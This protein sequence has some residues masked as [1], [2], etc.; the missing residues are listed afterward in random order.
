MHDPSSISRL[1]ALTSNIGCVATGLIPDARAHVSRARQEAAE[2]KYKFGYDIP[3]DLLARRIANIN[4]VST[5]E[6]AMRPLGTAL[7]LIAIDD[8]RG[9]QV[10]KCDPAGHFVGYL[11][12][13]TGAKAT[14][15]MNHMEKLVKKS[16]PVKEYLGETLQ[17][18]LELSITTLS[19]VLGQEF[20]GNELEIGVVTKD[21]PRFTILN[22]EQIDQIL[23]AIAEKD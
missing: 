9:P 19:S 17:E 20:K 7:T 3:I 1:F 12:T 10:Y 16:S 21:N 5:Q 23:T 14:D 6:A 22:N 2:F 15:V 8:E 11:A 4:Q 18:T 13:G